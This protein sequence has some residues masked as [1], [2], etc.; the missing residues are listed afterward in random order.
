M[1]TP[2]NPRRPWRRR[3]LIGAAVVGALVVASLLTLGAASGRQV[4]QPQSGDASAAHNAMSSTHSLSR[5]QGRASFVSRSASAASHQSLSSSSFSPFSAFGTTPSSSANRLLAAI[6]GCG[7]SGTIADASGFEDADGN[8]TIDN[9]GCTDWNSFAPVTWTGTAPY[10]S[11]TKVSGN[12]HFAGVTDAVS[13]TDTSYDGG[14]KQA[15]NCPGTGL[16]SV[17]NKS[18]IARLYLAASTGSNGHVYLDLA[19]VR[20]PLNNTSSDVHV[21]FEF[22]QSTTPC[23]AGSSPLVQRT[24]GDIL[25]IYNFQSGSASLA[26]SQ[27][28]GT[29]WTAET[30]LSSTIAEAKVFTGSTTSDLLKPSGAPDP[31]SEEFGEAGLDLTAA[32]ANLSN[33][34]RPC[35]KFGRA[36][37]ESRTSG[38]STSAQMM[39]I[40]GPANID[41]SNCATPSIVTTQNPASGAIGATYKDTATLSGGANY[42]STGSITFK[43]YSNNDCSGLLDTETVTGINANG[44]YQT[45]TGF[46]LQHAGTYYWVASFSGDGFNGPTATGCTD[47]P[48]VVAPNQPA[49]STTQSPASGAIGA[50]YK[51]TAHLTLGASPTGTITFKLYSNSNCSGLLDTETATVSGNGS[52]S[53]PTGFV[54]QHAGTYYWVASYGGDSDNNPVASGCSDEPVTVAPNQPAIS[55]TQSP[56]SGAI[57]ATYKDTAHLTLGASPTGTITFKLYSNSNCSGLLDTESA[58]VS[59]NGSYS[60]PTGFVLQHAGTYYWVASYGGDSDNNPVASGCSDEPVTVAPNQPAI[61]TTQ[62]PASGAIGATYKDTAHLTL[63]ASPTGTITFKLYSNS[64]C[65]GLLDTESATVSGNGSYSTPTGFVLQHAGTYYWVASYG[66]DSDNNPV[67]SGCSDEPVTVAPNQ[68]AISTT[69]SPASGAIGATYKDTAHLTLGASP[70]GTITFKL[71]SN[72][73]CSGLLDTESATV[74]GNGS[75]STPTGFVLQHAGTYYWVASYGGDSDNNPVA[76]GCSDEPVTVAPNQPAISTTQSPDSGAIGATYKDTAHLTLGASPTGTITF[77]LYS[78]SNCSGLLDTES[79]TVSGNGSYST[80]TGFVLQHAGTYY[81][82]ASYGGDSDNNPVAS[83]CSDEP[84]TV[85]PNQPA[86]STTQSPDS[87]AIGA[88]YKDTA[89]LTLGASPT[90]TITFK[91]YSNSNCSGLLDTETATVSGN[92]SYSTPTGFVLQHAGTYYWVASY[93]GDSDNNPV[94]SGCSDEPVTVAPNQPAISTTQNPDSGAIGAT[95]K[96]TAHLTLGASPTGTITFKLYSNSNCSGLL[97]TET[98]TVSGNGSYSTPTGFKIQSAGLYYWVASYGGDSDNLAA[99]PT[100]CTD[101]PVGV[102]LNQPAISTTQNPDSGAIGATYNDTAHLTL[103]ASPTGTITF[104]L[105]A[106]PNCMGSP[107]DTETATVSGNGNYSTPTGFKI[108]NAGTYYWVASYG[109]DSDNNPVASGC[110]DES[111]VVVPNQPA[112][113]TTQDPAS[114][115]VDDTYKDQATLSGTVNQDGSGSITFKLYDAADCGG[116]VID[117]ETVPVDD[118]GTFETP[119]GVQLNSAGTYYW[120][121]SFTGDPNNLSATSGCNDEPVAVNAAEIHIVKTADKSQVNAGDPIG[122]TMTVWNSGNGDAKGVT[123]TDTLPTNPGL[124]WQIAGQGSGWTSACSITAGVLS[125]GPDTVPASTTK[126]AST[127]TVHITSVTNKTTGGD[128][129]ETSGVVDNTGSVT[130]SNDGN[131]SSEAKICVAAPVIHIL[132]TADKSQ[133]NAGDPIGFTMTVWNSGNGDAK[134]VTLTDTLPTN[135]GLHWQIAGQGSGWDLGLLDHRW[136]TELRPGDG[137]RKHHQR[138]LDVHGAHHFGHGQDDRR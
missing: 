45:P 105:Y 103:G 62:S 54:L 66:G 18:D 131:D 107:L 116:N 84:V 60:T 72:S 117:T 28:T 24:K 48:V 102:A 108:Q 79:A 5:A 87:G 7:A 88:T 89:H 100:G 77:K 76:S 71:Y 17:N 1:S 14:V 37:G 96:D 70:T 134:G 104:N 133:V 3:S 95:Y 58:T 31:A 39:D 91:L 69:Q 124:H 99:G 12:F 81:W 74:S 9:A 43:L 22:N 40:V 32:T 125:C 121:A 26:Y 61:S 29:A 8:L 135:P 53:T 94:A 118:N 38:S 68:P 41:L 115:S 2:R 59:G 11:A 127:F 101:E 126:D 46:V 16:G 20:A 112:I 49:I 119:T 136:C 34:G 78:N 73:N 15:D 6:T 52:Y 21:G 130:T 55:T 106:E 98:A 120:V 83:G 50:T 111:V 67:A 65:S 33:N 92:G 44:P 30:T 27:W 36:F 137:A 42:D 23:P 114:G 47:E 51:D 57:G 4:A 122:F 93:G 13:G 63:G 82:V 97:D 123:L 25:I 90:G 80:P 109:G 138:R 64:N 35:E 10:Q 110:N 19:W 132:K 75:Y 128:C 56:A 129:A 113:L 86:I 85:A